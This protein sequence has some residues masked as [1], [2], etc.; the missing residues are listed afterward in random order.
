MCQNKDI[1]EEIISTQ[2]VVQTLEVEDCGTPVTFVLYIYLYA[3]NYWKRVIECI[4]KTLTRQN[5]E[6]V[7]EEKAN[8]FD[9]N[10]HKDIFMTCRLDMRRLDMHSMWKLLQVLQQNGPVGYVDIC[11]TRISDQA[12]NTM[13]MTPEGLALCAE[14]MHY[15]FSAIKHKTWEDCV[16]FVSDKASRNEAFPLECCNILVPLNE[17]MHSASPL[18]SFAKGRPFHRK[19]MK[20]LDLNIASMHSM[21]MDFADRH[22]TVFKDV[23]F[24]NFIK[25]H[26]E[27]LPIKWGFYYNPNNSVRVYFFYLGY[28]ISNEGKGGFVTIVYHNTNVNRKLGELKRLLFNEWE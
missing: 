8:E 24:D 3:A 1:F 13:E 7:V 19:F 4:I 17:K 14:F 5:V 2:D 27:E 18:C 23:N 20:M 6:L 11:G 22:L 12:T 25:E 9:G 28:V 21:K 16:K 10:R 15:T 26:I